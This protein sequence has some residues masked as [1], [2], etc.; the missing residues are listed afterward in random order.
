MHRLLAATAAL[1]LLVSG[2]SATRTDSA[3]ADHPDP[4]GQPSS[5]QPSTAQPS[6]PQPSSEQP[7]ESTN[8]QVAPRFEIVA[9]GGTDANATQALG[10]K[11]G[12]A[13]WDIEFARDGTANL[14]INSLDHKRLE[15]IRPDGTRTVVPLDQ[16]WRMGT[17]IAVG[18]DGSAYIDLRIGTKKNTVYRIKPAGSLEPVIDYDTAI[19]GLDDSAS[20]QAAPSNGEQSG[21]APSDFTAFTVDPAGRLVFAVNVNGKA[22]AGA[23]VRRVEADG[24]VRTIAGKPAKFTT[25]D[26]AKAATPAAIWP[27][28]GT[29]ALDWTTTATMRITQLE[30]QPDGT[31]TLGTDGVI[32]GAVDFSVLA[33]TSSGTVNRLAASQ[34]T[35]SAS[36]GA[37]VAEAPFTREGHI[38]AIGVLSNGMSAAAGLLAV[39]TTQP[40]PQDTSRYYNG[41][42]TPGQRAILGKARGRAIRLIRPDGSFSTAALGENFVLHGGYLYVVERNSLA[43]ELVLGRVKIPA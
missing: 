38:Q 21:Q 15:R 8:P 26:A 10:A 2:C 28:A 20:L 40:P 9:G 16:A 30:S 3:S 14:L 31:I 6:E 5:A 33:I 36:F 29:R 7:P 43:D 27:P 4:A 11:I 12:G 41:K 34:L 17:E 32:S 35:G 19:S 1:S 24:T 42:Y 23:V 22:Q 18:P 39:G 13:V 25:V 37:Q